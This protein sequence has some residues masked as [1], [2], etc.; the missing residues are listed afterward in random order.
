VETEGPGEGARVAR[1]CIRSGADVILVAGGD[2]T[3]NEVANG[4]VHESVPLGVLSA[5]TANMLATELGLAGPLERVARE[6]ARWVPR[7]IAAGALT[8]TVDGVRRYFLMMAGA[9]LDAH[10]V[11]NV[12]PNLKRFQGKLAFWL[13]GFGELS[14]V[15]DE[16]EVTAGGSTVRASFA[17][18][19][20]IRNYGGSF[21]LTPQAG[22][23]RDDFAMALFEGPKAYRYLEY[24]GGALANRLDHTPGVSLLHTKSA[25]FR[26]CGEAPVYIQVDGESAGCLPARIDLIPD[27]LT[28]LCPPEFA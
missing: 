27:A 3:I 7:R 13:A 12:D 16:F 18:A 10:V 2:G 17:L 25:E 14:R 6:V 23:L 22:L 21:E 8:T 11:R 1:E 9:G 15:L 4:M 5:G 19:S 24:L 28:L 26:P 20:R